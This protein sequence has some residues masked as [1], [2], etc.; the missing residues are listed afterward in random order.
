MAEPRWSRQPGSG[1]FTF[2]THELLDLPV[3]SRIDWSVVWCTLVLGLGRVLPLST[4]SS[5]TSCLSRRPV[6]A[7]KLV[8]FTQ[9][10]R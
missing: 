7:V 5:Q 8:A 9:A 10:T 3:Q 4:F 1:R 6:K 2:G